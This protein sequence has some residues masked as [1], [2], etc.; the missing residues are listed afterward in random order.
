MGLVI[1]A[2]ILLLS[3]ETEPMAR[4]PQLEEVMSDCNKT[5]GQ[6]LYRYYIQHTMPVSWILYID[7][8]LTAILTVDF[9]GRMTLSRNKFHFLKLPLSVLDILGLLPV[10]IIFIIFIILRSESEKNVQNPEGLIRYAYYFSSVRVVRIFRLGH[11]ILHNKKLRIV[12]VALKCS[13]NE[14]LVLFTVVLVIAMLFGLFMYYIAI[15]VEDTFLTLFEA[16]WWALITMATVGYGDFYPKSSAG[17]AVGVLCCLCGIVTVAMSTSIFVNNF[18]YIYRCVD[19]IDRMSRIRLLKNKGSGGNTP[20]C[21]LSQ[22]HQKEPK[23][24]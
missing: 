17:R 9:I 18:I 6:G 5:K 16:Q 21:L 11:L 20:A 15:W 13:W 3:L 7:V 8:I 19:K 24:T 23:I 1:I 12:V 2:S 10:W 22:S 14:M 4:Q